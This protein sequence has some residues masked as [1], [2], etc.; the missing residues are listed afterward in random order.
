M[1]ARDGDLTAC[2]TT[3]HGLTKQVPETAVPEAKGVARKAAYRAT[4]WIGW[5]DLSATV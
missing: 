5:V 2:L 1:A 3:A 4:K